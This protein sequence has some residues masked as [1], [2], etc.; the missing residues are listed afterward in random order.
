MSNPRG[1]SEGILMLSGTPV[2]VAS[3]PVV[4][5]DFSGNP[6]GVV[7]MGR[8]LDQNEMNRLSRATMFR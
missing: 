6:Q 7:I 2:L 3:R 5:A 4:H 1:E 8:Y